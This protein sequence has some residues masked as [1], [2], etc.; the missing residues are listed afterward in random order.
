MILQ[1]QAAIKDAN[2]DKLQ[3][4]LGGAGTEKLRWMINTVGD[5]DTH[6]NHDA[7]VYY[8]S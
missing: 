3:T 5:S 7:V 1:I 2:D 4:A 8:K 6:D